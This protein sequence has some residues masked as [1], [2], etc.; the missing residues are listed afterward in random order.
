[1]IMAS[2]T[3]VYYMVWDYR[4]VGRT[5]DRSSRA[6][7]SGYQVQLLIFSAI[8]I[9]SRLFRD[10]FCFAMD[11]GISRI[12]S[13]DASRRRFRK[14]VMCSLQ[15]LFIMDF[16]YYG[17]IVGSGVLGYMTCYLRGLLLY[18]FFGYFSVRRFCIIFCTFLRYLFLRRFIYRFVPPMVISLFALFSTVRLTSVTNRPLRSIGSSIFSC[19]EG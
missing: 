16:L 3:T 5:Y 17:P 10:F 6:A 2:S 11:T 7:I 19:R 1:M 4:E 15:V 8:G 14:R 13:R 18:D 12:I 9:G